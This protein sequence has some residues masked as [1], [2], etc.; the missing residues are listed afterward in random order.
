[1]TAATAP[2][3]EGQVRPQ[4]GYEQMVRYGIVLAALAHVLLHDRRFHTAVIAGAVGAVA[5]A[6]LIWTNQVRPVRRAASWYHR[7]GGSWKLP[8]ARPQ[9]RRELASAGRA[10]EAGKRS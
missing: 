8:R 9:A 7:L 6:N 10:L 4:G 1:M 2:T 3:P 5:F